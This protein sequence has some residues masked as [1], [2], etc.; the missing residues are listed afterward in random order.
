M[1]VFNLFKRRPTAPVARE[2]LKVLLAHERAS[3]GRSELVTRLREDI[4]AL[5]AK[6]I[7]IETDNVRVKMNRRNKISTLKIDIEMPP[8]SDAA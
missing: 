2:R 5:I 7:G 4:I 8:M 1:S 3:L 6:H